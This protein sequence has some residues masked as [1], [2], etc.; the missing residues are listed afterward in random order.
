MDL[1]RLPLRYL[2]LVAALTAALVTACAVAAAA[3]SAARVAPPPSSAISQLNA[4]GQ[5]SV[6]L[7]TCKSS[8]Y[9]AGRSVGFRL[10]MASF[11]GE[12]A[13]QMEVKLEVWRRLKEGSKYRKL[14]LPKIGAPTLAKDPAATVY[15]RDVE[16]KNVETSARYRAR[17]IFHWRNPDTG[18]LLASKR[19]WSKSCNQKLPLPRLSLTSATSLPV[20]GTNTI[21]HTLTVTNK[22]RSEALTVPVAVV[23]DGGSPV[24]ASIGSVGPRQ[25]QDVTIVA[26]ACGAAAYAQID[27]LRTLV[28]L[29]GAMRT[30]LP[31]ARCSDG[32]PTGATV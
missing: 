1:L 27:P 30:P 14:K 5:A 17:A 22:G 2:T 31:L 4:A 15:Q 18:E 25:S 23:V 7:R 10:R 16:I 28:R 9:Y 12:Q 29:R 26:P 8:A 32:R 19:I 20:A 21:A 3:D 24:Y 6:R 11:S 13:Q